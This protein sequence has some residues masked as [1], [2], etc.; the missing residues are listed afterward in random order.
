MTHNDRALACY[1]YYCPQLRWKVLYRA[2]NDVNPRH[3]SVVETHRHDDSTQRRI[4]SRRNGKRPQVEGAIQPYT[5]C[6]VLR[7]RRIIDS[8]RYAQLQYILIGGNSFSRQ[9]SDSEVIRT[10]ATKIVSATPFS[11][12][13]DV[14]SNLSTGKCNGQ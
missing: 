1:V 13:G 9:G 6:K 2:F 12:R 7:E 4:T 8:V 14:F 5:L 11:L 10:E 3:T